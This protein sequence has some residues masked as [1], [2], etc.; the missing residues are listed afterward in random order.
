[1][2]SVNWIRISWFILWPKFNCRFWTLNN[3]Q[4]LMHGESAGRKESECVLLIAVTDKCSFKI[5]MLNNFR[6]ISNWTI[7]KRNKMN[8]IEMK[9]NAKM[10]Q[11]HLIAFVRVEKR[12]DIKHPPTI[13]KHK[14]KREDAL[15]QNKR[16]TKHHRQ[17]HCM[18]LWWTIYCLTSNAKCVSLFCLK[19]T[20]KHTSH[21]MLTLEHAIKCNVYFGCVRRQGKRLCARLE[22]FYLLFSEQT[23]RCTLYIL[24]V[25]IMQTKR[26]KL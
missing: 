1:M 26:T 16:A 13:S 25:G 22:I 8:W 12:V 17:L 10:L 23:T 14:K 19:S 5:K 2:S 20:H 18:W 3:I 11:S 6:T 15:K 4:H 9:W 24:L 21:T 7:T